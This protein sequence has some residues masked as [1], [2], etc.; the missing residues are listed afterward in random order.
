MRNTLAV[1]VLVACGLIG[2]LLFRTFGEHGTPAV[3]PRPIAPR[4]I[5][6]RMRRERSSFSSSRH[7]R[8]CSSRRR[9]PRF[10]VPRPDRADR[11]GLRFH[12]GR[13]RRH[14]DQ[15]S[16][17]PRRDERQR[18]AQRPRNAR[19]RARRRGAGIRLGGHPHRRAQG[20]AHADPDR[21]E[22]RFAGGPEGVRDRQSVRIR[23]NAH[24]RRCLRDL[25][26]RFPGSCPTS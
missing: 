3:D 26:A 7:R 1:L 2:Y 25:G 6:R 18:D 23:S 10:T 24:D 11:D 20:Q 21:H 9:R 5:W 14:R 4:E 22:Q 8:W 16:R 13:R 19:S 15:L 12:L 17:H